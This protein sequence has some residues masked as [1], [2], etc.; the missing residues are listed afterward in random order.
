[1]IFETI[2][3]FLL[4]TIFHGTFVLAICLSILKAFRKHVKIL[5]I[6]LLTRA[7]S[8]TLLLSSLI[9]IAWYAIL[10]YRMIFS[11][12]GYEQYVITDRSIGPYWWAFW[13]FLFLPYWLSP[14]ILWIGR[15]RRSIICLLIVTVIWEMSFTIRTGT[16]YYAQSGP[17]GWLIYSCDELLDYLIHFLAYLPIVSVT[18]FL[19]AR[20]KIA[21]PVS[22]GSDY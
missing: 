14:Q 2:A 9:Y 8:Y 10:L 12:G 4:E 17:F 1:M 15:F 3:Q 6:S 20:K 7:I 22:G 19:L 21:K 13:I 5:D 18:Y 16:R 11:G